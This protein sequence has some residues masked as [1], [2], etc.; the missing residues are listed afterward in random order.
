MRIVIRGNLFVLCF[1]WVFVDNYPKKDINPLDT[2]E[3]LKELL[4]NASPLY[5]KQQADVL[6]FK[7]DLELKKFVENAIEK[8]DY[9]TLQDYL[10]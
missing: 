2:Y 1:Y 5:L 6:A 9:P 3:Q 10:K 4:P 8:G 7:T